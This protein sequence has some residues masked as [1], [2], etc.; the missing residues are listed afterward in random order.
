MSLFT[1]LLLIYFITGV[2]YASTNGPLEEQWN[3]TFYE[4]DDNYILCVVPADSD[5]YIAVGIMGISALNT[6]NDAFL[7]KLD[8]DGNLIWESIFGGDNMDW[9]KTIL[10][11]DENEYV[12]TGFTISFSPSI[13]S[14]WMVKTDND[15]NEIGNRTYISN[16]S[17]II[18]SG[19]VTSDGGYVLVGRKAYPGFPGSIVIK[20]DSEGNEQWIKKFG[21]GGFYSYDYFTSIKEVPGEGFIMAG[22]TT[23]FSSGNLEDGWLLKI[24]ENGNELW[25]H[26]FGDLDL[27]GLKSVVVS[28]DGGYIAVGKTKLYGES[29]FNA[30]I[31]KTDSDGNLL[32]EKRYF[33]GYDSSLNSIIATND[34]NY[35]AVGSVGNVPDG[36]VKA[37]F[38]VDKYEGLL[39]KVDDNGTEI[40]NQTFDS[41]YSSTF[42]SIACS[43]ESYIVAGETKSYEVNEKDGLIVLYSDPEML[44]EDVTEDETS[45]QI[46]AEKSPLPFTVTLFS[47]A[48]SFIALKRRL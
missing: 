47:I 2:A 5:S 33:E 7:Y 29:L 34:G 24:D 44:I 10:V 6:D 22:D 37:S 32:W 9:F 11:T 12:A 14:A 17:S 4:E 46:T 30:W 25:N 42:N 1:F 20:T 21:L 3:M 13:G 15:G 18:N 48:L 23:S 28:S 35:I 36:S 43:S 26:S 31:I 40:W 39:L 27:D 41:Y 38:G 8:S 45:S 16:S 19:V